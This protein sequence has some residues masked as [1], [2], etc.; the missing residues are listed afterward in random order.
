MSTEKPSTTIGF[1]PVN[2]NVNDLSKS[3]QRFTLIDYSVFAM[4]LILCTFI[5]LYFGWKDYKK[6]KSALTKEDGAA[7]Y[8][9]G[10]RDMP[11]FPIALSLTA[12]LVSGTMLLGKIL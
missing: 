2:I 3:L 12:S 8:L 9:L 6:R 10:G 7:E 1:D 4:M 11:V 5:G